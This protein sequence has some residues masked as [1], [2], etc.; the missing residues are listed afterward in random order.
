MVSGIPV[1]LGLR[2]RRWDPYVH[3]VF[4]TLFKST[5]RS[6]TG[7]GSPSMFAGMPVDVL[8]S[9]LLAFVK[10]RARAP[11]LQVLE[12]LHLLRLELTQS[13]IVLK[14]LRA[15]MEMGEALPKAPKRGK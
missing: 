10:V 2:T 1:V 8:K 4:E 15:S 7:A 11:V 6:S 14:S 9:D 12:P 5:A 3:V 13:S